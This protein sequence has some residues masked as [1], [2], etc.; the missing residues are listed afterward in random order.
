VGIDAPRQ[1]LEA[2]AGAVADTSTVGGLV[3]H[4]PRRL[5]PALTAAAADVAC[6]VVFVALGRDS[7]GEA[8]D[9]AGIAGVAAPFLLGLAAGWL[10]ARAW[11]DPRAPRTGVRIWPVTVAVGMLLRHFLWSRGTAA[12]FVVVA[13]I[14]LFVFLVGWRVIAREVTRRGQRASSQVTSIP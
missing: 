7:H 4:P 14:F 9:L 8:L 12:A 13:T 10:V 3:A 6:I 2:V 5:A 11:R 1:A